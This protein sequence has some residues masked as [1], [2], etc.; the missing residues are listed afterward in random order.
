MNEILEKKLRN[1]WA[2]LED[3]SYQL[4]TMLDELEEIEEENEGVCIKTTTAYISL[5][6]ELQLIVNEQRF[7][8]S[9]WEN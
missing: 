4:T 7:I 8:E 5:Q 9:L 2:T 6:K 1:R 3:K